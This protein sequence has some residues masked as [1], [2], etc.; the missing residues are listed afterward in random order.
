MVIVGQIESP[1]VLGDTVISIL[2]Y[3]YPVGSSSFDIKEDHFKNYKTR[4]E[5][6]GSSV[7][8]HLTCRPAEGSSRFGSP[9]LFRDRFTLILARYLIPLSL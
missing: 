1:I 2:I 8:L 7:D 9:L 4:L 3:P 6:Y 5:R